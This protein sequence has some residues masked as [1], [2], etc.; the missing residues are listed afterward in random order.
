MTAPRAGRGRPGWPMAAHQL[1]SAYNVRRTTQYQPPG[2]PEEPREI[3]GGMRNPFKSFF[4]RKPVGIPLGISVPVDPA[5]HASEFSHRWA[6]KLDEFAAVRMEEFGIPK[7]RIG[8]SDHDHGIAWAAFNP[9]EGH[10]GGISPGGR[11][12]P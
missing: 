9:Y 10:A 11:G 6:D 12:Q 8:S 5:E 4:R 2:I 3:V 7:D 1:A